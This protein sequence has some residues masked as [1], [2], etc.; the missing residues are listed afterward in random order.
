[1]KYVCP[2]S[3][4][5]PPRFWTAAF[6]LEQ[7]VQLHVDRHAVLREQR[8]ALLHAAGLLRR[9][10]A[11]PNSGAGWTTLVESIVDGQISTI[12]CGSPS[13]AFVDSPE[14]RTQH[15]PRGIAPPGRDA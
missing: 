3:V 6:T 13:A 1:M 12:A 4:G 2:N 15:R 7:T 10:A 9:L 8:E 14:R 5:L 11:R